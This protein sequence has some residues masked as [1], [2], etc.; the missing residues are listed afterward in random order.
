MTAGIVTVMRRMI[1]MD[2][3]TRTDMVIGT[4]RTKSDRN[5]RAGTME[6]TNAAANLAV[7]MITSQ[8]WRGLR[9]R[10]TKSI[11]ARTRKMTN[12]AKVTTIRHRY[13]KPKILIARV[14]KNRK[15]T[16]PGAVAVVAT[17]M[18]NIGAVVPV[19]SPHGHERS[20]VKSTVGH[21]PQV[22]MTVIRPTVS[23]V[24]NPRQQR[25]ERSVDIETK[26]QEKVATRNR[27]NYGNIARRMYRKI[28]TRSS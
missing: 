4:I 6:V 28:Q 27:K 13:L 12:S 11:A 20:D 3:V 14:T 8:M 25:S 7:T 2:V 17:I 16:G 23:A 9:I 22:A 24:A 26:N 18:M 10:R 5:E 21:R 19:A 1:D 15:S